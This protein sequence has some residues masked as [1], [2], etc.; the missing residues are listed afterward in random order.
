MGWGFGGPGGVNINYIPSRNFSPK[1][2]GKRGSRIALLSYL[3]ESIP[4]PSPFLKITPDMGSPYGEHEL[5]LWSQIRGKEFEGY[6]YL[7]FN[8]EGVQQLRITDESSN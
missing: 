4:L 5:V 7:M 1:K 2:S 3:K 6:T 8:W